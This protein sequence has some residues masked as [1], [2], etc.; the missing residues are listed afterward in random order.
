MNKGIIIVDESLPLGLKANI[1]AV[2]S[3]SLG[4]K[5]PEIIGHSVANSEQ[6]ELEGI[7]QIPLPILQA[8]ADEIKQLYLENRESQLYVVVFNDS[9]L[10]TKTYPEYIERVASQRNEEMVIHGLLAYGGR[11]LINRVGGNLQLV[12]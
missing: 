6:L 10:N 3:L 5:H 9:A 12:R 1:A 4:K 7:T 11:K 2:L 8:K